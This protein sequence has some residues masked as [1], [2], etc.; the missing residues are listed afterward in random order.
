MLKSEVM[1]FTS[2]VLVGLTSKL[3]HSRRRRAEQC[4]MISK[5]H[6]LVKT[7]GAVA[8]GCSAF[9]RPRNFT[10]LYHKETPHIHLDRKLSMPIAI[11]SATSGKA[12]GL[13]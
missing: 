13:R 1:D 8:V 11:Q 5:F 3:R 7:E 4:Q 6:G 2:S 12:G 9:V 10:W